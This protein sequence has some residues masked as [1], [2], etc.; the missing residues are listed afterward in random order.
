MIR[1][2]LMHTS[3]DAAPNESSTTECLLSIF[4]I[5]FYYTYTSFTKRDR[6]YMFTH[7]FI[8]NERLMGE[9]VMSVL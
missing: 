2:V 3:H 9:S 6:H 7:L 8:V 5:N 1:L 4:S